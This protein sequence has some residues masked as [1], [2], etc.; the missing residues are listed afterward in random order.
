MEAKLQ[1]QIDY[2]DACIEAY[3]DVDPMDGF[4][5]IELLPKITGT[6]YF[7]EGE[8]S[9]Y[10]DKFQ[11]VINTLVLENKSVNRAENQANKDHPE[12]YLL[13]HKLQAAYEVI[14]AIRSQISWIKQE[15][16]SI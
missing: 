13:R 1:S 16:N 8:R 12:L 7:L 2:L 4:G 11:N 10:H 9:K 5:L 6:I 3:Q 15:K 14:N